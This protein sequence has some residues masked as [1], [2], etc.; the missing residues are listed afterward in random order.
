[1]T[2]FD[3][4]SAISSPPDIDA[5]KDLSGAATTANGETHDYVLDDHIR[6]NTFSNPDL[7]GNREL[8]WL[9]FNERVLGEAERPD[10]PLMERLKFLTI[11]SSNLD[12]FFMVRLSSLLK[13]AERQ[14]IGAAQA[15]ASAQNPQRPRL[16]PDDV[17]ETLDDVSLKIRTDLSRAHA[18]LHKELIPALRLVGVELLRVH[19]LDEADHKYLA[20]FFAEQIFPI[21]TP[22]AVDS[23]HPFPYLSNLSLY[24]AVHFEEFEQNGEPLLAFLEIPRQLPRILA[25]PKSGKARRFILTEDVVKL[26][27][28]QLFPWTQ[29]KSAYLV[30]VTRNLDYQL[31]EGEVQDLMRSIETELRDREQKFVLRLEVEASIPDGLR[32]RLRSELELDLDDIYEVPQI[33][34]ASDLKDLLKIEVGPENWDPPFN[35]R[36]HPELGGNKNFFEVLQKRDILLHHPYDSFVSIVEFVEQ[37]RIDPDVLAI[38]MTLY[39]G[40]GNSPIIESL[41]R[42]AEG[43][44]QVTVVVELKARFDEETNIVWAKR[45]ERAGAHVVFGFVG[46]KTHCKSLLVVRREKDLLRRYVHL[47]TGNYNHSTAKLYTDIGLLTCN[48]HI[49]QDV[50]NLFNLLTGFN[51]IGTR[52]IAAENLKLSRKLSDG[53]KD[54]RSLPIFQKLKVAPFGLREHFLAEI[55][56]EIR[57]HRRKGGGRIVLKMNALTDSTLVSALYCASDQGVKIDLFVRGVCVLLPGI[58]DVS[59]NITVRS[60]VDRFLEHSRVAWF[61]NDGQPRVFLGSADF[62]PRNMDRRIEIVWPV[63]DAEQI[64]KISEIL[65]I[66]LN[67]NCRAHVMRSDGTYDKLAPPPGTDAVRSQFTFIDQ[68][69]RVGLK[70]MAYDVALDFKASGDRLDKRGKQIESLAK[71]SKRKASRG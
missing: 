38:K 8:S 16:D 12:E 52:S 37:A 51:I 32:N 31:L 7:F 55:E 46:L 20:S 56:R 25:L 34:G 30:R 50:V 39:R 21:L 10:N 49:S 33:V 40:G 22:L 60:V 41:L 13:L 29:V 6:L 36:I 15:V 26:F 3:S 45:L 42:A 57:V 66:F 14:G 65:T 68:A 19:E 47:S 23:A 69:R 28:S 58:P 5:Q 70:S 71:K 62:M 27:L 43:G 18:L 24:L 44:K 53:R 63:L 54:S 48:E 59:E 35:P 4:K 61:H 2:H 17:E 1:M 11:F 9:A 67:D 64:R